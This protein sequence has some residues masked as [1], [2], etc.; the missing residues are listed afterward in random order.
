MN[1][2]WVLC[3]VGWIL[4]FGAFIFQVARKNNHY[5]SMIMMWVFVGLL[6]LL[7]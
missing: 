4:S 1:V 2:V 5:P 3:F 6:W 7:K